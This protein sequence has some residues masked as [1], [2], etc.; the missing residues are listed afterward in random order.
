MKV[1]LRQSTQQSTQY[2]TTGTIK[3]LLFT[4]FL[5]SICRKLPFKT[6]LAVAA[7]KKLTDRVPFQMRQNT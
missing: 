4:T 6:T 5:A 2:Y 7:S 1:T 3:H